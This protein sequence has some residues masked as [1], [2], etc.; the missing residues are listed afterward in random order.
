MDTG[1]RRYDDN[2]HRYAA[3]YAARSI[4]FPA[5]AGIRG[6]WIPAFAGMTEYVAKG[7]V[8]RHVAPMCRSCTYMRAH[9]FR[10]LRL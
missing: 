10:S 5:Y 8:Y 6:A 9:C 3:S 1:F 7:Q 4:I 2:S